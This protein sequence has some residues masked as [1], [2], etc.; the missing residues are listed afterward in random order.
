MK[1]R[2]AVIPAAGLGTRMLPLTKAQPK[3]MLPVVRKPTIQYVLEEAYEA[4]IRE[5]LIITGKHKRAIEDHF[6]R[7][8]HEVKNPHLDKLDKILDDINIYYARQR[9]QRG[10]GDAIKYA[11]AFV[12]DE[13]FALLLGDTITLPS[14]TAGIIESYEEL[15]APVIAV[16]EVQEEKIS[17]YGVVGIGRYINERIFEINKLVE[18]PEIHEAPSNLAILGRYIL[19]P[20]IFEYLE[21]VKPDKKGEIQLTDALELMVQNGKKIYGYVFKGRRYDIGNIFD[22]LRANIELGL[23]DEE[24][25]EKLRELI[26]SLVGERI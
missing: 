4:G 2:K 25:S 14:C 13:P 1:V 15:K 12:G 10:L 23:E 16:E 20:E 3:E 24:L 7:Y 5:V 21:E 6:D 18:K 11:E 17:L 26:K 19:T 8:E 9:V 22:W